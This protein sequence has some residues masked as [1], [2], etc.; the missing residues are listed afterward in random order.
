MMVFFPEVTHAH[1][2]GRP[3]HPNPTI[4]QI[5]QSTNRRFQIQICELL[6]QQID[7]FP[8]KVVNFGQKMK[9][10]INHIF[11]F[12]SSGLRESSFFSM[13]HLPNSSPVLGGW[14]GGTETGGF[15]PGSRV[16]QG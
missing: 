15:R 10:K 13:S 4:R 9:K 12:L 2:T 3:R 5:F 14:P 16:S 1:P 6:N 7:V 11:L 8:G